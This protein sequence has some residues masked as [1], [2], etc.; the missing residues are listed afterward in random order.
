MVKF[1]VLVFQVSR[2]QRGIED[3]CHVELSGP[4]VWQS[5]R[6]N[7]MAPRESRIRFVCLS[8]NGFEGRDDKDNVIVKE[9]PQQSN[10]MD[11]G[12]ENVATPS[13][14]QYST[15]FQYRKDVGIYVF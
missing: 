2:T 15:E 14:H 4:D 11:K 10:S 3:R 7:T 9:P 13:E 5:E 12:L 8:V 6:S 1:A